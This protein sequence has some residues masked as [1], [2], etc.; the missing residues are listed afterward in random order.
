M[1]QAQGQQGRKLAGKEKVNRL[2]E[3]EVVDSSQQVVIINLEAMNVQYSG[4]SI[5]PLL[6]QAR[7]ALSQ[8]LIYFFVQIG[9]TGS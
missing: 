7:K 4:K 5:I 8:F 6:C 2:V 3:S 1:P 9:W